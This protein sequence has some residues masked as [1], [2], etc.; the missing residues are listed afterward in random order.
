M[1]N[2]WALIISLLDSY[3]NQISDS[4][5]NKEDY[6]KQINELNDYINSLFNDYNN[7]ALIP[8]DELN[9]F[10]KAIYV[11]DNVKDKRDFIKGLA[12][13]ARTNK[14]LNTDLI[15]NDDQKKDMKD[16]IYRLINRK[17]VLQHKLKKQRRIQTEMSNC[18]ELIGRFS[19]PNNEHILDSNDDLVI[20]QRSFDLVNLTDK[21]QVSLLKSLLEY[22]Y[23]VFNAKINGCDIVNS[24]DNVTLTPESARD[25]LKRYGFDYNL[26]SQSS[27]KYL[28]ENGNIDIMI[29]NLETIRKLPVYK[30][31]TETKNVLSYIL[32]KSSCDVLE[33]MANISEQYGLDLSKYPKNVFGSEQTD[34]KTIRRR[35]MRKRKDKIQNQDFADKEQQDNEKPFSMTFFNNI[36]LL[37]KYNIPIEKASEQSVCLIPSSDLDKNLQLST[38]YKLG[39]IKPSSGRYTLTGLLNSRMDV[40]LDRFIELGLYDYAKENKSTLYVFTE[41]IF[42]R[43]KCV[44]ENYGE[45][46]IIVRRKSIQLSLDIRKENGFGINEN[47]I[48]NFCPV[49]ENE[50]LNDERF[51]RLQKLPNCTYNDEVLL[52]PYI[53]NLEEYKTDDGVCYNIDGMLISRFK[54]LRYFSSIIDHPGLDIQESEGLEYAVKCNSLRSSDEM[55]KI[56]GFIANI[57]EKGYIDGVSKRV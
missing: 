50:F 11:S 25:I 20:I 3:K 45:E 56:D 15:Y 14:N 39:F 54:V 32:C 8:N 51:M 49:A 30:F 16:F 21:E 12:V 47:N 53:S 18:D 27:R 48:D 37:K 42:K 31:L 7:I 10:L 13:I 24:Y 46:S 38:L 57:V 28:L 55:N 6:E 44:L 29:S 35:Y 52:H 2:S 1:N 17:D 40:N 41:L 34:K 19:K 22:E 9:A 4:E 33:R 36:E 43:L 23:S 5:Y 26:M